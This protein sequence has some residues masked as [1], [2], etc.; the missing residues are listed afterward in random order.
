MLEHRACLDLRAAGQRKLAG[1]AA[2]FNTPASIGQFEERIARGA[3]AATL[4]KGA[5][6][7]ALVDHN[8]GL[9][10][11]RT[12][13]GTLRLNEDAKGLAFEL[14]LPDTQLGRDIL[15]MVQRR[16]INSLSFGFT[17]PAGGDTWPTPTTRIL[18]NVN[19][20]EISVLHHLPAY[21]DT[22]ISARSR[23]TARYADQRRLFVL[24]LI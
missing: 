2:T 7:R 21:S 18:R 12:S 24:G 4:S 5:D 22:S 3:F 11:A 13:S 10:L 14:D 16:D 17:M 19:L 20:A 23:E 1:Y 15:T 6:V 9:L 8:P